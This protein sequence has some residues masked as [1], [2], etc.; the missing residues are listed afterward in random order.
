MGAA[1][2][3]RAFNCVTINNKAAGGWLFF[4]GGMAFVN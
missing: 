3:S 2:M 4:I 1:R